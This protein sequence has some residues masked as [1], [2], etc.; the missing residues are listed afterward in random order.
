MATSFYGTIWYVKNSKFKKNFAMKQVSKVKLIQNNGYNEIIHEQEL[1]SKLNHPF[2]VTM[3]FSFQDKDY[4][5][6]IND[7]MSGGDLRYWYIQRKKF[8]EKECKFIISCIILGLEYLHTNK[9]I[10]R[11]L[12]PENILFDKKDMHTLQILG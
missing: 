10:Q 11:D 5:Y 12:K 8:T 9:I 3:N 4:L 7:L 1:S 6:M 2:L